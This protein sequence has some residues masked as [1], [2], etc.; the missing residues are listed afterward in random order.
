MRTR[1]I[2]RLQHWRSSAQARLPL[3]RQGL[4]PVTVLNYRNDRDGLGASNRQRMTIGNRKWRL[5]KSDTLRFLLALSRKRRVGILRPEEVGSK[6]DFFGIFPR[7]DLPPN[8]H[9]AAVSSETDVWIAGGW[10]NG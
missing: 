7:R 1:F 2:P 4:L 6:E 10:S 9:P 3:L 5:P 8:F